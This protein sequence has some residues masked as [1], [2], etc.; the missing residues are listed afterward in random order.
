MKRVS[1]SSL[2]KYTHLGTFPCEKEVA[3]NVLKNTAHIVF[4]FNLFYQET[5]YKLNESMPMSGSLHVC[6]NSVSEIPSATVEGATFD[7]SAGLCFLGRGEAKG[8]G[9]GWGCTAVAAAPRVLAGEPLL[10]SP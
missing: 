2:G 10:C 6:E 9:Q 8:K 4:F 3:T 5:S 1:L 7:F